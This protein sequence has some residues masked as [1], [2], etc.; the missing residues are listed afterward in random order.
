MTSEISPVIRR[1][2]GARQWLLLLLL[3]AIWGASF[4]FNAV[5]LKGLPPLTIVALRLASGAAFL[6]IAILLMACCTPKPD[7]PI[8]AA[9]D[10]VYEGNDYSASPSGWDYPAVMPATR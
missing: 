5:A 9:F 2:M 10:G 1:Q 3:G 6:W 8:T 4:F 7:G